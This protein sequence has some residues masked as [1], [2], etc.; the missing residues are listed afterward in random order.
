[1]AQPDVL[2]GNG[3]V[4]GATPTSD[5]AAIEAV[6]G[7]TTAKLEQARFDMGLAARLQ[8]RLLDEIDRLEGR[9]AESDAERLELVEKVHDR[10][11]MLGKIFGSRSWRWAQA[12]RR[13]LGRR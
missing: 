1:M 9:L 12:L 8:K 2:A 4:E 11:R 6:L 7:R 3:G 10:D 13:M 5:D